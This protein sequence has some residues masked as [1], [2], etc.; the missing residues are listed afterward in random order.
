M[1]RYDKHRK[2]NYVQQADVDPPLLVT[3]DR[4]EEKDVSLADDPE[5]MK[6]I[7]HWK[8]NLLPWIPGDEMLE[9]IHKIAGHGDIE[10]W[11]GTELVIYRDETITF[12]G[13]V[14]GGIRCRGSEQPVA[15][16]RPPI[17]PSGPNPNYD[18]DDPAPVGDDDIPF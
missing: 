10:K 8:E 4:I 12:R 17:Q 15:P 2:R 5:E 1:T 9:M 11:A 18:G 7:V 6:F 14:T 13:K 3:I 16:Q